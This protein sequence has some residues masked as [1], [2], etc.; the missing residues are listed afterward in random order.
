[1]SLEATSTKDQISVLALGG[2]G[3]GVKTQALELLLCSGR[4]SV[5]V[6][7]G[8][9]ELTG[10]GLSP[11]NVERRCGVNCPLSRRGPSKGDCA[12]PRPAIVSVA[13]CSG[14]QL[15][16]RRLQFALVSQGVREEVCVCAYVVV[17]VWACAGRDD[18]HSKQ[19]SGEDARR[20]RSST[21]GTTWDGRVQV[22]EW[23]EYGQAT[24]QYS[25]VRKGF[26]GALAVGC[27][28]LAGAMLADFADEGL[29]LIP[30]S[31]QE[32]IGFAASR[33]A[34]PEYAADM[35]LIAHRKPKQPKPKQP[36][37][38]QPKPK[39]PKPKQPLGGSAFG[40][41][42]IIRS[43]PDQASDFCNIP[44]VGSPVHQ[45][46]VETRARRSS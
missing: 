37:P 33:A 35:V 22:N 39:Q 19:T 13:Y 6:P 46:G 43:Q 7:K 24:L 34:L 12:W 20:N 14:K 18:S 3:A 45:S 21:D 29:L 17:G 25:R 31:S 9:K 16:H 15:A 41:V 28:V 36:K 30:S 32:Q 1:M 10:C 44:P 27:S 26:Q 38:K 5:W 8:R 11:V 2:S 23:D 4:V 40:I 42:P